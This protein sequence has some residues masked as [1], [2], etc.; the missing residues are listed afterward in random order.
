MNLVFECIWRDTVPQQQLPSDLWAYDPLQ[1]VIRSCTCDAALL[2]FAV[3]IRDKLHYSGDADAAP[4]DFP[5][6]LISMHTVQIED[7]ELFKE[8]VCLT[9]VVATPKLM[10]GDVNKRLDVENL[11]S[12]FPHLFSTGQNDLGRMASPGIC[13]RIIVQSDATPP[14]RLRA[15]SQYSERERDFYD[16]RG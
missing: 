2:P 3:A 9:E 10:P 5:Q 16:Q 13:H 1:Q 15:M 11:L 6:S 12:D 7:I 8:S 4:L 14:T